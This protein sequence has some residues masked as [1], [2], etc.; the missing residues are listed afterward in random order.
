MK[1]QDIIQFWFETLAPKQWWAKDLAFDANIRQKFSGIHQQAVAGELSRWRDTD[2]GRLA[3]VIILDQFS[4]NMFRDKAGA[5]AFDAQALALSKAAVEAGA[6][7]RLPQTQV[8]FLIMPFMHSESLAE[9][10]RAANLFAQYA[11]EGTTDFEKRHYAII[12]R[13]G[14]YPHRNLILGRDSTSEEIEFLNQP[15]SSF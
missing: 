10:Q 7:Q 5:F 11:S 13:F 2:D 9:H 6:H 14:R 15:G 1:S 4:R 8:N 12:E 3:E